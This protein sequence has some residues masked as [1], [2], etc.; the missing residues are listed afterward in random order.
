M[1]DLDLLRRDSLLEK[2]LHLAGPGIRRWTGMRHDR[3][4]RLQTGAG[5]GAVDLL[6]ALVDARLVGGTLDE[7]GTDSGALDP[8]LDVV[9]EE[10]G[11]EFG[12][13]ISQQLGQGAEG[14]HPA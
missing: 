11:V 12:V 8:L 3:G 7:G 10:S 2:D 9:Y 5:G 6:Y 4:P 1:G 13:A 14:V